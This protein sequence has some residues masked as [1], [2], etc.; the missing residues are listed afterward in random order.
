MSDQHLQGY[1]ELRA[2]IAA[3]QGN[4]LTRPLVR[5]LGAAAIREQKLGLYKEVVRRTGHSGQQIQLG[6][7][8]DT[9][10]ETIARGTALY[11]E[12][13]TAPHDIYPVNKKAL[14]FSANGAGT[15]LTGSVS[16]GFRGSKG[17]AKAAA[18][19]VALVF[20][21]HVHHPGTKAHPFMVEGANR[22]IEN[23]GLAER[24]VAAWNSKGRA[25]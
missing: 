19:G 16:S 1:T 18:A 8:T 20:A 10:V 24:I 23:A 7:V 9:S 22:A 25:V 4:Q 12:T 5:L 11:A 14:F 3:L 21:K 17:L 15:R 6:T 13:G 2:R